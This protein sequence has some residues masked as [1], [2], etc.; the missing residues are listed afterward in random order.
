MFVYNASNRISRLHKKM[1]PWHITN[2][3][4]L[5]KISIALNRNRKHN[6]QIRIVNINS[7]GKIAYLYI[8]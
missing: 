6:L 5:N 4:L 7:H 3:S 2:F 8:L 1:I